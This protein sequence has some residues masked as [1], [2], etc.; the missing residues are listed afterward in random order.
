MRPND[1]A[2]RPLAGDRESAKQTRD[3]AIIPR[4]QNLGNGGRR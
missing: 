2:G 1:G 4:A 3:T